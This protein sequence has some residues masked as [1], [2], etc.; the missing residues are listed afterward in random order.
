[1]LHL[2]LVHGNH[3]AINLV[4]HHSCYKGSREKQESKLKPQK[5][6]GE[7]CSYIHVHCLC[8]YIAVTKQ[9]FQTCVEPQHLHPFSY[10]PPVTAQR[11]FSFLN[12]LLFSVFC[13]FEAL[14]GPQIAILEMLKP[15]GLSCGDHWRQYKALEFSP[16]CLLGPCQDIEG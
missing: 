11:A 7:V 8:V 2:F 16:G 12:I 3:R 14:P 9:L 1:M 4:C 15:V 13:A 6:F 5:G 10:P